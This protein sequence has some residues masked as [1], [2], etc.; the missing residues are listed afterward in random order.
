MAKYYF[1]SG[2]IGKPIK[3]IIDA[4]DPLMAIEK[5]FTN[6]APADF[7]KLG[8]IIGINETGFDSFMTYYYDTNT[9]LMEWGM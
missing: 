3:R 2:R 8:D 1:L 4:P 9:L 5:V 7:A 6:L